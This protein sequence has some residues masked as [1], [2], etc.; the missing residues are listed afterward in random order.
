[1]DYAWYL[2]TVPNMTKITFKFGT[3]PNSIWHAPASMVPDHGT[4]YMKKIQSAII[5]QTDRWTGHFST[6]FY[7]PWFRLDRLGNN[8]DIIQYLLKPINYLKIWWVNAAK[9]LIYSD[10]M[11]HGFRHALNHSPIQ[12]RHNNEILKQHIFLVYLRHFNN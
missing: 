11:L 5:G 3:E 1:M 2:I 4:L 6:L 10:T 12:S 7:I 9:L 8:N